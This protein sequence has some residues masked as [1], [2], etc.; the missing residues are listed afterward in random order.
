MSNFSHLCNFLEV[1]SIFKTSCN[2]SAAGL[3]V[4]TPLEKAGVCLMMKLYV[5]DTFYIGMT[6]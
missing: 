6:L 4:L 3:S 2:Y 1:T 5:L